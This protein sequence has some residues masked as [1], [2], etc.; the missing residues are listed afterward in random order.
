MSD[1]EVNKIVSNDYAD[2]LIEYNSNYNVF[3][4]FGNKDYVIINGRYALV[5]IPL[6]NNSVQDIFKKY[7]WAAFPTCYGLMQQSSLEAS[8]ITRIQN[9]P[10]LSLRGQGVLVGIID[11]GIEYTNPVFQNADKTTRIQNIWDQSIETPDKHPSKIPYG[12]IYSREEINQA[13]NNPAPLTMVPSTD[14]NGHGTMLAGVIAGSKSETEDFVGVVPDAELVVVKVKQAKPYLREFLLIP[15]DAVCFQETDI[16]FAVTYLINTSV[17]LNK[18]IAIC[19]GLGSSSGAHDGKGALSNYLSHVSDTQGAGIA[20]AAGNEGNTASHYYG[21]INKSIGYDTV[22]LRVGKNALGFTAEL[23]G[24]LPNIFSV[25]V[26]SPSGEAIPRIPARLGESREI[27]FLFENTILSIDYVLVEYTTGNQLIF[28]RFRNPAEGIWRIRVYGTG[29]DI[30]NFNIWL[31]IKDFLR[32]DTFFIKPSPE[33]TITSPGNSENSITVT[34]Y[35]HTTKSLYI[36]ASR[37]YAATGN[38]KPDITAPGV[39]IVAPGLNNTFSKNSGTSIAAAITT[40]VAAMLLEWGIVKEN[41]ITM[42]T[43]EI[44]NLLIRGA[45]RDSNNTYP[46]K[47]WGYGILDIYSTFLSIRSE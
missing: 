23:W 33:T 6:E 47:E 42:D 40:G 32:S 14:E 45:Q 9:I 25:D 39:N 5:N 38:V 26:L 1:G 27:K 2:L 30:M 43:L 28:F 13:L 35:D 29:S 8:G 41:S 36:N 18:P 7:G 12:T 11:T 20:I 19:I 22:E 46:N 44:K 15:E 34:A 31:P 4:Q 17:E 37:G 16:K 3:E 24:N 10:N 21:T